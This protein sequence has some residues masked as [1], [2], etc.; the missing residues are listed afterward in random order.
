MRKTTF[1]RTL[2]CGVKLFCVAAIGW[3]CLLAFAQDAAALP[4]DPKELMLL[5]AKTNGLTGPDVQPWHLKATYKVL[6]ETGKI[7]DR[8]T[9]EEFW[10]SPAKYRRTFTGTTFTQTEY[11]TGSGILHAGERLSLPY[12][13]ADLHREFVNPFSNQFMLVL[14]MGFLAF[15]SEKREIDGEKA[16]CLSSADLPD[17][18][19][20]YCFSL[21]KPVIAATISKAES[22]QVLHRHP[23]VIQ[24]RFVPGDLQI[25]R[26]GKTILSAHIESLEML[27]TINE[28]DFAPTADAVELPRR[29]SISPGV[30]GAMIQS[31]SPPIYPPEAKAAGITGTVVLQAVIGVKGL[32]TELQVVSGPAALQQ[33]AMDAVRN[34]QYRPYL[35][36]GEPVEVSTRINVVFTLSR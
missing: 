1:V 33:A 16:T 13:V 31:S 19:L 8:G 23:I 21:D 4:S 2:C 15:D 25:I 7:T 17:P 30:A 34:W 11:G 35:L 14:R 22:L 27:G 18:A 32:V 5:A 9:Y 26:E 20:S 12:L 28:I 36:N 6:D 29:I 24:N 10:A 3:V